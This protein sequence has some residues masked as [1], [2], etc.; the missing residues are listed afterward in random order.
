MRWKARISIAFKAALK[1]IKEPLGN[2]RSM[3]SD[4]DE[5][6]IK[7]GIIDVK[8]GECE[9]HRGV[10][11]IADPTSTNAGGCGSIHNNSILMT[12]PSTVFAHKG[13]A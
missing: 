11:P 6:I 2:F 9:F 3:F 8:Y 13:V 5:R 7:S 1:P 4:K 12:M 10:F